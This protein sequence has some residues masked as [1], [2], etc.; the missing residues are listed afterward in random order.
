[1]RTPAV[2]SISSLVATILVTLSGAPARA[3]VYPPGA[4]PPPNYQNGQPY[5]QPNGQPYEPGTIYGDGNVPV[6]DPDAA[7]LDYD[8]TYDDSVAQTYDDGYDPQAAEPFE[9]TLAPYGSWT[10][11]PDYGRVWEPSPAAVGEDFSPYASNGNWVLTEY[12]WTWSSGWDWGWAPFHYGRWTVLGNQRW[13]WIPGTIWGPAWVSWR[14]GGGYV[15]WAPL[16]PRQMM[17]GSPVGPRS[18]WR[19]TTAGNL[20]RPHA[21]YLSPQAVPHIFG[22]MSVVSNARALPSYGTTVRVNA[23]PTRIGGYG[24]GGSGRPAMLATVAP[25]A[26][27]RIAIQPHLGTPVAM[28]PWVQSRIAQPGPIYGAPRGY[29]SAIDRGFGAGPA[30]PRP[31]SSFPV[32]SSPPPSSYPARSAPGRSLPTRGA[33]SFGPAHGYQSPSF[34][35]SRGPAYRAPPPQMGS[36]GWGGGGGGQPHFSAPS[37]GGFHGS[38]PAFH[39]GGGGGGGPARSF[40]G[41]HR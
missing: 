41:R 3:Q 4:E 27:P 34:P 28:R 13:G 37:G 29:P 38:P 33:P 21:G 20:G 24:G 18:P 25:H 16:P 5:G 2:V 31:A 12:G 10:D 14:A 23:G 19:F 40:G 26:V 32:H 11:D 22:R 7:N 17:I 39:G 6:E 36:R 9:G 15:G 30:R 35:A 1:M 8:L